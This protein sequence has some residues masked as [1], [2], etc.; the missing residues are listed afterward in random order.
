[1][2]SLLRLLS[3]V[4]ENHIVYA[5]LR[6]RGSGAFSPDYFALR[7]DEGDGGIAHPGINLQPGVSGFFARSTWDFSPAWGFHSASP[8]PRRRKPARSEKRQ[9]SN[10][11]W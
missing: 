1:M 7:M 6:N 3:L 8:C 2:N 9:R 5:A 11:P 4:D 10:T